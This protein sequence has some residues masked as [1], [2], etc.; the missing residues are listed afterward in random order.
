MY[1]LREVGQTEEIFKIR[2]HNFEKV[3]NFKYLGSTITED[4]E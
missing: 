3:N 2:T 4:N 1:M